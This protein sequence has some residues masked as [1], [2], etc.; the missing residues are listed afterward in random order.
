VR[1]EVARVTR[2]QHSAVKGSRIMNDAAS[3]LGHGFFYEELP[4]GRRFRTMGR[5][6]TET[7]LVA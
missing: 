6:I 2:G 3:V 1:G 4:V 7:D 5:T